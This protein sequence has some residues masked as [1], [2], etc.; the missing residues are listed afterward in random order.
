LQ[1]SPALPF[2]SYREEINADEEEPTMPHYGVLHN[3]KFEGIQEVRGADVYGVNNEKLGTVEDVIFEHSS[4]EI[5]YV[6][7]KTGGWL[8]SKQFLVPI[9]RIEPYGNRED[10]FY[11]EMDKER[12]RMLPEFSHEALKSEAAWEEYERR[13]RERWSAGDTMSYKDTGR[14]ITPPPNEV[15]PQ[16]A[17]R[18][19]PL[20]GEGMRTAT[21]GTA[22]AKSGTVANPSGGAENLLKQ[23]EPIQQ[24]SG[25][26]QEPPDRE[27]LREPGVYV[28]DRIPEA[29]R[30]KGPNVKND[31]AKNEKADLAESP[32][33]NYG[34]R[35]IEFQR[36]LREGRDKVVGGC[37]LC[38]TQ[39]KAA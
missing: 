17:Q 11:A 25:E 18:E 4:G 39:D 26:P 8:T 28:L 35:W 20:S 34:R 1:T 37:P 6:V 12:I 16:S 33:V 10:Q 7:V 15:E 38:G 14:F 19:T 22:P 36:K 21:Q 27:T 31:I 2:A 13:Y 9:N 3:Q 32:N 29:E 5:R 30:K 23:A 24:E